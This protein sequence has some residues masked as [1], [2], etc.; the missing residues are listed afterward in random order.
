M[1]VSAPHE[2][3]VHDSAAPAPLLRVE[4]RLQVGT[5]DLDLSLATA[6]RRVAIDGPS[7]SG[8]STCLRLLAGLEPKARGFLEVEGDRWM[9]SAAGLHRP[10]WQ[11]RVGYVP[12]DAL[13]FPHRSVRENLAYAGAA[14]DEVHRIAR[15]FQV[16]DLLDRRPRNLSGGEKQRVALGRALLARPGLLL[17][18]EPFAALDARLRATVVEALA[19]LCTERRLPLVLASH[20]REAVQSLVE[21]RWEL[22]AG[23][24]V[25][26]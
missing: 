17:L 6:T 1:G 21:E 3:A 2:R 10:P 18:D 26:C 5:L 23:R 12:Q 13:L 4:T 9:D 15:L 22:S 8:K 14:D 20:D 24:L 7:G 19:A 16:S 25:A 11:R